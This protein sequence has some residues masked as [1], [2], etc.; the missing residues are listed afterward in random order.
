[1]LT[2]LIRSYTTAD[3]HFNWIA[4]IT[5]LGTLRLFLFLFTG[6]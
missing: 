6:H 2:Y 5:T 4:G 1:M 3:G